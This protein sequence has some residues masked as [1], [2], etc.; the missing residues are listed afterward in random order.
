MIPNRII[1]SLFLLICII[2]SSYPQTSRILNLKQNP[3]LLTI[4]TGNCFIKKGNHKLFHIIELNNYEPIFTKLFKNIQGL[5]NFSN[6]T[7][8]VEILETKF[9]T[10]QSTLNDLRPKLRERRGLFNLLGTGIKQ[11]TGNMDHNDFEQISKTISDLQ[12]NN[13]M[14]TNEN[15]EQFKI[16]L[17]LQNRINSVINKLNLQQ[18][19]ITKNII[20]ARLEAETSRNFKILRETIKISYNLDQLKSHLENIFE[21]IQLART[22]I[23]PKQIL[24]LDE[25]AFISGILEQQN[26][27]PT[28]TEQIYEFLD[29]SAYYNK[30]KLIFIVSIPRI[31]NSTYTEFLLEPLTISSKILKL[32]ARV[33][34]HNGNKTYF[35]EKEC[36]RIDKTKLCNINDLIDV[37]GDACY[38]N[39]L[40]GFSANCTFTNHYQPKAIK[41]ITDNHIVITDIQNLEVDSNCGLTKRNLSGTYLIEF[42]NCSV[43]ING[44]QYTNIEAY[45]T[46]LTFVM[47]L[48]G[49]H[50]NEQTLEIRDDIDEIHIKN[51]HYMETLSNQHTLQTYTSLSMSTI[52]FLLSIITGLLWIFKRRKQIN[53]HLGTSTESYT[54]SKI[55]QSETEIRS[56]NR[57]DSSSKG[58]VVKI[59]PFLISREVPISDRLFITS[60]S[61]TPT[62]TTSTTITPHQFAV[63][64]TPGP[65]IASISS[66][67]PGNTTK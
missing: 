56:A 44:T 13:R 60:S 3:G 16:N 42:H 57:D 5:R 29:L 47:P 55:R 34:L 8:V 25:L 41:R 15:N 9:E 62:T 38:S 51:R 48:D 22:K 61:I 26:I 4:E 28:S 19:Q 39:L 10:A 64:S 54:K 14:L 32:P 11:I 46:E 65:Q 2:H 63:R 52:C 43:V 36:R 50:I 30:T 58:G 59:E 45:N 1:S 67:P 53:L 31:D 21:S 23:I 27:R 18:S 66:Y 12:I 24:S 7:D 20:S 35:I 6:F 37:T 17:Q 49:L 40:K 33:A